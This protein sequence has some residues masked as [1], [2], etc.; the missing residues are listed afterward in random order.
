MYD[1]DGI[2]DDVTLTIS[3]EDDLWIGRPFNVKIETKNDSDQAKEIKLKTE[4]KSSDYTGRTKATIKTEVIDIVLQGK[5]SVTNVINVEY[6]DYGEKLDDE[7]MFAISVIGR[8]KGSSKPITRED[9]IRLKQPDLEVNSEVNGSEVKL[10]VEFENPLDRPL[11]NCEFHVEAPK[12]VKPFTVKQEDI[13]AKE[14][15]R[16]EITFTSRSSGRKTVVVELDSKL[17]KDIDGRVV[18]EVKLGET[19]ED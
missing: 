4:I 6:N 3:C 1:V 2:P 19:E 5:E 10:I 9:S 18:V 11:T 14:K 8:V 12:L 7:G 13:P 17:L 16:R 15:I